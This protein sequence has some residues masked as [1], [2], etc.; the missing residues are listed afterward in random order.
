MLLIGVPAT[1]APLAAMQLVPA[2]TSPIVDAGPQPSRT[3]PPVRPLPSIRTVR[4]AP[5]MAPA[6][7][8]IALRSR[9]APAAA[10]PVVG[11]ANAAPTEA[12]NGLAEIEHAAPNAP[13]MRETPSRNDR[14]RRDPDMAEKRAAALA[15]SDSANDMRAQADRV[16][17]DIRR[18]DVSRDEREGT[19]AGVRA[20]RV[21]AERRDKEARR[22][23]FGR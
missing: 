7:V 10:T 11:D 18:R 19:L 16:E 12:T 3:A 1:A 8:R 15:L 23:I 17:T 14:A 9:S 5:A 21:E 2:A 22:L 6:P 4:E 13:E 20:M